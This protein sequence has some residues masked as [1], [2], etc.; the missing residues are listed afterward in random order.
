MLSKS[1]FNR[2][3]HAIDFDFWQIE[4]LITPASIADITALK[5]MQIDVRFGAMLYGG[6]AYTDYSFEDMRRDSMG[7]CLIPERKS[8]LRRQHSGS[9]WYLQSV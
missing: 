4:F 1:R 8:C 2:R 6:K 9:L 5:A 3:V 7:V